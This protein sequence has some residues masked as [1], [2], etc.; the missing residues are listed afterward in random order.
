[1]K[2][3]QFFDINVK[4]IGILVLSLFLII[5][6]S[7]GSFY[8]TST[9]S[10]AAAGVNNGKEVTPGWQGDLAFNPS[11]NNWLVVSKSTTGD[12]RDS[13]IVGAI[14]SNQGRLVSRQFNISHDGDVTTANPVVRG[15]NP[16]VVYASKLNKYLVVWGVGDGAIVP[17][18]SLT[19]WGRFI[20]PNGI[21]Q[22]KPFLISGQSG[23]ANIS[24]RLKYDSRLNKFVVAVETFLVETTLLTITSTGKIE[25]PIHI[26]PYTGHNSYSDVSISTKASEYCVFY[27]NQRDNVLDPDKTYTIQSDDT[28]DNI[29]SYGK[30]FGYKIDP[31]IAINP[32]LHL[33]VSVPLVPGAVL[34]LYKKEF[35]RIYVKRVDSSSRKVER[36]YVLTQNT[37]GHP[38]GLSITYNPDSRQYLAVWMRPGKTVV[39]RFLKNCVPTGNEFVIQPG[40]TGDASVAYNTK[41]NIYGVA[42]GVVVDSNESHSIR[43]NEN[44]Y[45]FLNSA[46]KKIENGGR[47]F[48]DFTVAG[49]FGPI[50]T[51]NTVDGTFSVISTRDWGVTRF[52]SKLTSHH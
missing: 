40:D 32:D 36:E 35:S 37:D 44:S 26:S 20:S 33:S 51:A 5:F 6:F 18:N 48:T 2:Q 21:V 9:Y 16:R 29:L 8:D 46:G 43:G 50:I 27:G 25:K 13:I 42:Y 12:E 17:Q 24:S 11:K 1:M 47:I 39:G 15:G 22:G 41:S 7:I 14:V 45:L 49:N 3:N 31:L 4:N 28:W 52:I 10:Q 23:P 38:Q 34:K 19:I 30:L